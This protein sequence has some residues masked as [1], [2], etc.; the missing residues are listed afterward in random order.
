[1]M[2]EGNSAESGREDKYMESKDMKKILRELAW[3][4]AGTLLMAAATNFFFAPAEMVPG[5]FTGLAIIIEHFSERFLSLRIPVWLGNIMLNVPLIIFA[6]LVRGWRF[7]YRTLFA[8]MMFSG[9][10]YVLPEYGA[11]GDDLVLTAVFG[12]VLMGAG[13][14]AVLLGKGTT[15]GTDTIA[16]LVQKL[17]PH[18]GVAKLTL[19]LDALVVLLSVWIFGL[20]VSLYA[21]IAVTLTGRVA[22]GFVSGFRNAYFIYVI[23][24][25]YQAIAAGLMQKL[26]RGVTMLRGTGM[27]SGSDRPVLMCAVSR[28]QFV[29]ARDIVKECDPDAF[30]ILTDAQEVRGEGF[31]PYAVDE[32]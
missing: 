18:F 25:E 1:M 8:A 30:L 31:M 21:V 16:A 6:I 19:V 26:D 13:L 12:G 15:G 17:V 22:D 7:M 9:W 14:G 29:A 10:L 32:L 20:R 28:R 27:Y 4:S 24:D 23:S 5:G 2:A 11:A 3:M